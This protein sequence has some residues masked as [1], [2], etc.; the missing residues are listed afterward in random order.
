MR[1]LSPPISRVITDHAA[2]SQSGEGS[3]CIFQRMLGCQGYARL[4]QFQT[5]KI[6][7]V[8]DALDVTKDGMD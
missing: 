5:M 7:M 3:G 4:S 6:W 1:K 2:L 8:E